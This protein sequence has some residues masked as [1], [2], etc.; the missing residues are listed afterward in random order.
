[1]QTEAKV[2]E[3]EGKILEEC[4]NIF[5]E[6]LKQEDEE[7]CDRRRA[8]NDKALHRVASR[9]GGWLDA[10]QATKHIIATA[11]LKMRVGVDVAGCLLLLSRIEFDD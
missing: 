11:T 6:V 3:E 7:G 2:D 4:G 10:T 5:R 9:P 8:D 1:M